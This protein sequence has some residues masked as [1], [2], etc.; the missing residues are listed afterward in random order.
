MFNPIGTA[1]GLMVGGMLISSTQDWRIPFYVFGI[2]GL[3]LAIWVFFLPD[4]KVAK[5]PGEALFSKSYFQGWGQVFKVKSWWLATITQVFTLF[6]FFSIS[7]WVPTLLLRSYNADTGQVGLL[8]G[9]LS[10]LYIVGPLGGFL[11]DK[12]RQRNSNGRVI[13]C[14]IVGILVVITGIVAWLMIGIP[15]YTWLIF[16]GVL[17]ML[18][19]FVQPVNQSLIHD[20]IP[21][22]VRATAF[23]THTLFAQLLGGMI[24]PVVVGL[25]SDRLGGGTQ[26]IQGG[27]IVASLVGM[28]GLVTLLIMLKYYPSDSAKISDTVQAEK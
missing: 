28:L 16:Y 5:Q 10:I 20:V 14:I 22:Q 27:L 6:M 4:Y 13:F 12:W 9:S 2:P 18:M 21:V 3:L 17:S 11:A 23:G 19:A 1:I 7:S 26:G 25:V 8:L 15:M 24:G